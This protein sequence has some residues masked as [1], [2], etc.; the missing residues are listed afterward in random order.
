MRRS[1]PQCAN[2]RRNVGKPWHSPKNS[3][4]VGI[5]RRGDG[6]RVANSGNTSLL[7][8]SSVPSRRGFRSRSPKADRAHRL[9]TCAEQLWIEQNDA[10]FATRMGHK[11]LSSPSTLTKLATV[12][13][14]VNGIW[15]WGS[16]EVCDF[17]PIPAAPGVP[18]GHERLPVGADAGACGFRIPARPSPPVPVLAQ[19]LEYEHDRVRKI[20]RFA[21]GRYDNEPVRAVDR[22]CLR[23]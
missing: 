7:H 11:E 21:V 5:N 15:G 14:M 1:A 19:P 17:G 20:D 4:N 23:R 12:L 16:V 9:D 18:Q 8:T 13:L 10:H 22:R 3:Q 2:R 6:T